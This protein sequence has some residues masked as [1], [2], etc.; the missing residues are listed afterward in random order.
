MDSF[1]V[2]YLNCRHVVLPDGPG[3]DHGGGVRDDDDGA[4]PFAP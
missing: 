4:L 2:P 1:T 3:S